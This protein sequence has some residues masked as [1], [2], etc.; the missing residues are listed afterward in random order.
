MMWVPLL[1]ALNARFGYLGKI[2][3]DLSHRQGG[4]RPLW[5]SSILL[6]NNKRIDLRIV[7]RFVTKARRCL[8]SAS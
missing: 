7:K 6:G 5:A 8:A 4:L 3:N 1:T 2:S